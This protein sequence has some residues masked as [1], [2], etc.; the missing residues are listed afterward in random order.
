MTLYQVYMNGRYYN[1]FN[2][3]SEAV[4]LQDNLQSKY[5]NARVEIRENK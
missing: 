4:S 5:P 3:F 1:S 2:S